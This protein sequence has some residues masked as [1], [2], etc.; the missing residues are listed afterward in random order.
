MKIKLTFLLTVLSFLSVLHSQ[1]SSTQIR[2]VWLTTNWH[3][4][5]PSTNVSTTEQKKQLIAKLDTLKSLN[6]NTVLF[7]VRSQGRVMFHSNV[8]PFSSFISASDGFDPLAF[9][10]SECHKRGMECHAWMITY[11]LGNN[12]SFSFNRR[13]GLLKKEF[14]KYYKGEWYLDPGNPKSDEYLLA[15]VHEIVD[16]YDVDGIHFDYIRYPDEN[17]GF[18]DKDSY[19]KYGGGLSLAEWRRANVTN[20]VKQAYDYVKSQKPWI[21]VSS[22]PLG[23]YRSLSGRGDKWSGFESV[24][25]DS[26]NWLKMGIHDAVYPMMYYDGENFFPYVKDWLKNSNGRFIVPGLGAYKLLPN[27]EDWELKVLSNQMN[28][29]DSVKAQGESFFRLGMIWENVKGIREELRSRYRFPAKLPAM[30]WL[31]HATPDAP[32]D[33]QVVR[34]DS[35]TVQ[36]TWNAPSDSDYTYTIYAVDPDQRVDVTKGE[37]VLATELRGGKWQMKQGDSMQGKYFAVTASNRFHNESKLSEIAY[38]LFSTKLLK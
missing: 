25:Q 4:D 24:Y 12:R 38:F 7:Q 29:I 32:R 1:E 20:F 10:V 15:I 13:S 16:N 36:L 27:D 31:S 14:C 34:T 3:L 26:Y 17:K 28:Y 8:E 22:S 19:K 5:W 21:Q 35:T 11:P 37:N 23:I 33:F 18:P 9:A 2:A 6:F 30:T